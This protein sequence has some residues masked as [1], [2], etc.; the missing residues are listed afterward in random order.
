[1]NRLLR[2]FVLALVL[3]TGSASAFASAQTTEIT[4]MWWIA[5]ESGWGVNV[6]LQN[7]VAYLTFFVYDSSKNQIWYSAPAKYQGAIGIDGALVWSGNLYETHGP[8]FGGAFN[9]GAVVVRQAGTAT[10]SLESIN[11]S[12]LTYTVDGVSVSKVVQRSTWSNEDYT[13]TYAGG[14]SLSTSSCSPSSLNGLREQT[15]MISVDHAGAYFSATMIGSPSCSYS[16]IYNQTGKLGEVIG[17]YSCNDGTE[18]TFDF[19]EITPTISGFNGRM[20][21]NDQYCQWS[22]Y[23]GGISRA[24]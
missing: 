22:G 21:E 8:W 18:G 9:P 11:H 1:M 14:L 10:F 5:D 13:G 12:T 6:I 7:D 23:F 24:Q 17:N 19:F 3:L 2:P 4:D 16:G 15:G 20:T